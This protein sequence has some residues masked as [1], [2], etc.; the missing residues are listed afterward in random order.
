MPGSQKYL[1]LI[2][3]NPATAR[4]FGGRAGIMTLR[5]RVAAVAQ[6]V[7]ECTNCRSGPCPRFRVQGALLHGI[8]P[9]GPAIA[10]K[11][12]SDRASWNRRSNC[13]AG[14]TETLFVGWVELAKPMRLR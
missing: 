4:V 8:A 14:R 2:G 6:W 7:S 12:R 10:D 13:L 11:V 5:G 3:N 1:V 9:V